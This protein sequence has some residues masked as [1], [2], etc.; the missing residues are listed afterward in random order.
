[1]SNPTEV[2]LFHQILF[3]PLRL[4]PP[5][6]KGQDDFA[7]TQLNGS[8]WHKHDDLYDRGTA[9][10]EITRYAEFVYFHPFIRQFLYGQ[11][12]INHDSVLQLFKRTDVKE[13]E[14]V[15]RNDETLRFKVERLHLYAFDIK[16]AI[17][18]MEI[19]SLKPLYLA[20][21][22]DFLD[23][24][25]RVYP[26]Y[27]DNDYQAGHSP[28]TVTLWGE[29]QQQPLVTGVYDESG[30]FLA[31]VRNHKESPVAEHW[32]YL[33]KPFVPYQ[34]PSKSDKICYQQI[35]DERI[36]YM[37]YLAFDDPQSLTDGDM[38]RLAFADG[39]GSSETL[40]YAT[41]FFPDSEFKHNYCYDR[42]WETHLD[43]HD[44]HGW[45][46]TRYLCC[47]YAF[48]MI[49]K[50]EPYFF[51]D[52]KTGALSHFRHHYF[53]MGLIA[54]FHKAALLMLW[55]DLAEAVAKFSKDS[56]SRQ[57]FR[58]EVHDILERLLQF[59]HRYWFTEVSNQVQ[60]KEL[61]D[62]WSEHLGSRKLFD[63]VMNEAKEAHQFLE[64]EA[65]KSQTE[66]TTRLTVVATVGLV[67]G[68]A[69]GLLGINNPSDLLG[70]GC[71]GV[72][73][74]FV[75]LIIFLAGGVLTLRFSKTLSRWI[76][77][78]AKCGLEYGIYSVLVGSKRNKFRTPFHKNNLDLGEQP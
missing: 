39:A 10:D 14:V 37:A 7:K 33:L 53:Q 65:Q 60:A 63:R 36:P 6:G 73:I 45:M 34:P 56:Q 31:F 50:D 19:S 46:N 24:F 47:G 74:S 70:F 58:D 77:K 9:T 3:W 2:K 40:P 48:T 35:E 69:L 30:E 64:M 78:I 20:E 54:H 61:F 51:S 44:K 42:Y 26:P 18:V 66:M 67:V 71:A 43:Y 1:M 38:M 25:R 55:E 59:T 23:Q 52:G 75:V 21:V 62:W 17:L 15:L 29:N 16:V 57:Q 27:W 5:D 12:G 76:D 28:K 32:K 68:L 8:P 13:V 41:S 11:S 72:G 22:Q 49:G 4:I